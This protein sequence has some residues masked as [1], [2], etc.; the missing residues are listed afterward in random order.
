MILPNNSIKS[1]IPQPNSETIVNAR[2]SDGADAAL[3]SVLARRANVVVPV[4]GHP[5]HY[6]PFQLLRDAPEIIFERDFV[7]LH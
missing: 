7:Y 2:S 1:W 5:A 4:D 3:S 6:T